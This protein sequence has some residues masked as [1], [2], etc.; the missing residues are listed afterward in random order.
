MFGSAASRRSAAARVW[1]LAGA[2]DS[3]APPALG[4]RFPAEHGKA[5]SDRRVGPGESRIEEPLRLR[6]RP[7]FWFLMPARHGARADL[8]VPRES[9]VAHPKRGLKRARGFAGPAGRCFQLR[10]PPS[11]AKCIGHALV[12]HWSC[13]TAALE[14][15]TN[16]GG[17]TGMENNRPESRINLGLPI[18]NMRNHR[19]DLGFKAG[20]KLGDFVKPAVDLIQPRPQAQPHRLSP[21]LPAPS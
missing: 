2:S 19:G 8:Q 9:L 18:A 11:N 6:P 12:L 10:K 13:I 20:N 21:G 4:G 15:R 1:S 5:I 14:A 16:S 17:I 7:A 3:V